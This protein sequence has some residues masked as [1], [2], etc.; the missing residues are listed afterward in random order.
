[1]KQ[2]SLKSQAA[3]LT[4]SQLISISLT[5]II[6]I[7]LVR[8]MSE[9]DFGCYRQILFIG[10]VAVAL[11]QISLPQSLFYFY[12]RE[13]PK[14]YLISQTIT[15]LILSSII[16]FVFFITITR[17]GFSPPEI[18]YNL[19]ILSAVSFFFESIASLIDPIFILEAHPRR[20]LVLSVITSFIR[21]FTTIGFF[22]IFQ[23][24]FGLV[25]G[26]I[27]LQAIRF[28]FILIYLRRNYLA[29]L[30][31]PDKKLLRMQ[32]SYSLPM[33]G[34]VVIGIIGSQIDKGVITALMSPEQFAVYSVSSLGV[35]YSITLI[36]D[37]IGSVC[38]PKLSELG[39]KSDYIGVKELWHKMIMMNGILLIPTV[40]FAMV[41]AEEI[42]TLLY[43]KKYAIGAN[44]FRVN[45]LCLIIFMT[46]FGRIPQALGNTKSVFLSNLVRSCV[47]ICLVLVL[48][49]QFG[50]IGGA[51]SFVIALGVSSVIQLIVSKKLL[52]L[53]FRELLPWKRLLNISIIS[54][55][56]VTLLWLF[57]INISST[58]AIL[59]LNGSIF[60]LTVLAI[61]VRLKFINL[62]I[63][64][65]L[66]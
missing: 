16:G 11:M 57:N 65:Q 42:L 55:T 26:L 33:A 28:F 27:V 45:L 24:L 23:S 32:M 60:S 21:L 35:L 2:F 59:M 54:S 37:A 13:S 38:L 30:G 17:M 48:I 10:T 63:L 47:A 34:S 51:I 19:I 7:I 44:I 66:L 36:C 53:T 8:Y 6:P 25:L 22:L 46:E 20:L 64:K 1:M 41:Y 43:T 58:L 52:R 40:C 4:M 9:K 14:N 18:G 62:N 12:P 5:L 50:L 61:F 29:K 49:P 3:Y 15:M 56:V 39:G 31:F